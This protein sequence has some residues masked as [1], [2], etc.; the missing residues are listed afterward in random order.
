MSRC[1]STDETGLVIVIQMSPS[2]L[3]AVVGLSAAHS[4]RPPNVQQ[5][6][7]EVLTTS[8]PSTQ[9]DEMSF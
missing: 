1:E 3:V 8:V 6:V 9:T 7:Q 5:T 4:A 2:T